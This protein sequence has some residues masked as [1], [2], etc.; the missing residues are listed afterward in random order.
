MSDYDSTP[1]PLPAPPPPMPYGGYGV[2]GAPP[3][4]YLVWAILSTILFFLP[5]GIVSIVFAAQ[6]NS[7]WAMGD[8]AGAE[9]ASGLAK[10]LAIWSVAVAVVLYLLAGILIVAGSLLGTSNVNVN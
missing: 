7:K 5:L 4:N 3:P 1:P 2:Q 9:R 8:V 6:V 10:K